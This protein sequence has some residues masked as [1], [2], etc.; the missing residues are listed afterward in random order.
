VIAALLMALALGTGAD[1]AGTAGPPPAR[2]TRIVAAAGP[3]FVSGE[4]TR[5]LTALGIGTGIQWRSRSLF[6]P[7][8]RLDVNAARAPGARQTTTGLFVLKLQ[9]RARD[10]WAWP[11]LFAG[12]GYGT[13][14]D[15]SD[16]S[17]PVAAAVGGGLQVVLPGGQ[18]LFLEA[19]VTGAN[20]STLVPL[21]LGVLLP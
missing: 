3:T 2:R 12:L 7:A 8:F 16:F 4:N 20:E 18:E 17:L 9:L 6:A 10:A 21:R 11:Y 13:A 5:H 15:E 19:G 1:P 14:P